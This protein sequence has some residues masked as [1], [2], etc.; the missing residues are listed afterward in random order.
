[1]N[2]LHTKIENGEVCYNDMS[3]MLCWDKEKIQNENIKLVYIC[4][5]VGRLQMWVVK[6]DYQNGSMN[7]VTDSHQNLYLGIEKTSYKQIY[8]KLIS[9]LKRVSYYPLF[10]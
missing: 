5:I 1:M 8:G 4:L 6:L 3:K 2:L 10:W 9:M 7:M